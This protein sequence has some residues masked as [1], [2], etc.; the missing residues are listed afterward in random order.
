LLEF[1]QRVVKEKAELQHKLAALQ[2]FIHTSDIF[3][4]LPDDEQARLRMQHHIMKLYELILSERI[5]NFNR[6]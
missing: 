4:M 6:C 2:T 3:K 5:A 1:Q